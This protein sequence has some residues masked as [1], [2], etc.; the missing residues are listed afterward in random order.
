MSGTILCAELRSYINHHYFVGTNVLVLIN[1]GW[2]KTATYALLAK[3]TEELFNFKRTNCTTLHIQA[4]SP[5]CGSAN[6]AY[7][8]IKVH[9]FIYT[10]SSLQSLSSPVVVVGRNMVIHQQGRRRIWTATG[11]TDIQQN[12]NTTLIF[13]KIRFQWSHS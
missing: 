5:K 8:R 1:S 11:H 10:D 4:T 2:C 6:H 3:Y 7:E 9:R 13:N 12:K